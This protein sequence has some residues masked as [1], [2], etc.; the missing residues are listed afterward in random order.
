M[1]PAAAPAHVQVGLP[2]GDALRG[3][4]EVAIEAKPAEAPRTVWLH[5]QEV[6]AGGIARATFTGGISP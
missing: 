3:R 2:E 4:E 5:R 1:R 6:C